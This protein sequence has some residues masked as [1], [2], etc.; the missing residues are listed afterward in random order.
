[1]ARTRWKTKLRECAGTL[2]REL[3][4]SLVPAVRPDKWIFIVGCYNSGTELLMHLLGSHPDISS[5]PEE[6]QFLSDQLVRDYEVGLHRMWT[7]REDLFR[8]TEEDEGPDPERLKQE[9]RI[10]L[11]RTS[12]LFVEKSPPNMGR[13]RWLQEHFHN[14]HFIALVRNGYA[15]AEGIRRKAEPSHRRDGWPI[16]LCARQW[17]RCHEILLEDAE[18]LE[19]VHWLHYEDLAEDTEA[20]LG[21]LLSFLGLDPASRSQMDLDSRWN[22]HERN[23]PIRNMNPESIQ[24]LSDADLEVATEEMESILRTFGYDLL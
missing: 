23:E 21:E 14:A 8:L 19:R 1:M 17:R 13:T 20:T 2:H 18:H 5:L 12:P 24:R 11:D 15:V 16:A 4:I 7:L 3:R 22:V 9:W 6:G 10:R